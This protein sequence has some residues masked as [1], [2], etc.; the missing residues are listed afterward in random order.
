LLRFYKT[1]PNRIRPNDR[2]VAHT[3]F[4]M[5][6]RRIEPVSDPRGLELVNEVSVAE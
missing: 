5:F 6:G 3:G 2:M 4:L 1:D